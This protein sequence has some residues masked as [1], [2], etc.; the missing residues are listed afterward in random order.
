[1]GQKD[2][3]IERTEEALKIQPDYIAT[4]CPFCNT[5]MTDGIKNK[6]KE[7]DVKVLDIA[8]MIATAKD[9]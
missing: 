1:M 9:L 6:E 5:M 2:V 3:N 7:E 4:G 8:E